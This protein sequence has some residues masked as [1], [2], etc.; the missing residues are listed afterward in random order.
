MKQSML[1]EN[2]A[3][4]FLDGI[5]QGVLRYQCCTDCGAPQT[6]SRYACANCGGSSLQWRDAAGTGTVYATTVVTRAPSDEFRALAPFTLLLVD[7][8]EG[9]RVMAH[10]TP[11][12]AIGDRVRAHFLPHAGRHLV[13]FHPERGQVP[14]PTN[15]GE[16]K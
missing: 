1:S 12:L 7:L 4:P 15:P 2:H 3:T 8:D 9:S 10:G 6:L 11:G 16:D 5:A 13:V 14:L